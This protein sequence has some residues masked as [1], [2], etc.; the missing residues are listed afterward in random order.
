MLLT[1]NSEAIS[2]A[3]AQQLQGTEHVAGAVQELAASLRQDSTKARQTAKVVEQM[4]RS[5]EQLTQAVTQRPAPGVTVMKSD[6]AE[7]ASAA[8]IGRG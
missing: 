4:A 5:S 8:V 7:T 6:K 1:Y 2:A 3:S